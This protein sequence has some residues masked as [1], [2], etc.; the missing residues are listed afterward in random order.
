M[1]QILN[2]VARMIS[3]SF[4]HEI[5]SKNQMQKTT[6][7]F[8]ITLQKLLMSLL[9]M[10][11]LSMSLLSMSFLSMSLLLMSLLSMNL[12]SMSFL[13]MIDE[14][15]TESVF[16]EVAASKVA[17]ISLANS[18]DSILRDHKTALTSNENDLCQAIR[19]RV[20]SKHLILIS[21]VFR[22]MLKFEYK[23]ELNLYFQDHAELFLSDDNSAALLIILHLIH[24][25]VRKIS[26]KI[27]I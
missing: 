5:Y 20:S 15:A 10:S 3:R 17:E 16:E 23:K 11:L 24:D 6:L 2:S 12:L 19:I 21:S 26:R 1:K 7:I 18:N 22:T 14:S 8:V 4:N 9:S 13:S 27:D 25:E